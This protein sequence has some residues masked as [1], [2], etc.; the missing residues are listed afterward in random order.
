MKN[1]FLN[2]RIKNIIENAAADNCNAMKLMDAMKVT[3]IFKMNLLRI[4]KLKTSTKSGLTGFNMLTSIALTLIFFVLGISPVTA[5]VVRLSNVSLDEFPVLSASVFAADSSEINLSKL[6]KSDFTMVNNGFQSSLTSFECATAV[7]SDPATILLVLDCGQSMSATK[8]DF[9]KKI[10]TAFARNLAYRRYECGLLSFNYDYSVESG[11]TADRLLLEKRINA[12]KTTDGTN[13]TTMFDPTGKSLISLMVRAKYAKHVV[14]ISDGS[15]PHNFN[16][17]AYSLKANLQNVKF[18]FIELGSLLNEKMRKLAINT[19]GHF[20]DNIDCSDIS[21]VNIAI[22][23]ALELEKYIFNEPLCKIKWLSKPNC[24]FIENIRLTCNP[25][26]ASF[27]TSVLVPDSIHPQISYNV[28][29]GHLR[30]G[31]VPSNTK[32]QKKI[33]LTAKNGDV[34]VDSYLM[35]NAQFSVVDWGGSAPPFTIL[36]GE[37]RTITVEFSPKDTL[38]ISSELLL[39]SSNACFGNTI[40]CSG[41]IPYLKPT[42]KTLKIIFPN[43]GEKLLANKDTAIWWSG[44]VP[45]APVFLDYSSDGGGS[46][47]A[48]TTKAVGNSY[49][50]RVPSID[51]SQCVL[52]A[53]LMSASDQNDTSLV[54]APHNDAVT[55]LAWNPNGMQIVTVSADSTIRI[56]DAPSASLYAVLDRTVAAATSVAWSA[57]GKFIAAGTSIGTVNSWNAATGLPA[58]SFNGLSGRVMSVAFS[59]DS[60]LLAGSDANGNILIWHAETGILASTILKQSK[61]VNSIA[62]S[63]DGTMLATGSDDLAIKLWKTSDGSYIRTMNHTGKVSSIAFAPDS[64]RI[65]AGSSANDAIVF[66]TDDGSLIK[67]IPGLW[68]SAVAWSPDGLKIATGQM[69]DSIYI[70]NGND[71]SLENRLPKA[72]SEYI[73]TVAW[74]PFGPELASASGDSTARYWILNS[75]PYEVQEDVS[76]APWSI[77]K[78]TI[79]GKNGRHRHCLCRNSSR[80]NCKLLI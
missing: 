17:A 59:P 21:K 78:P 46:W 74:R 54:L 30:F 27:E 45:S 63:P 61:S 50:W 11:F 20:Y 76:D 77:V 24:A 65:V 73:T 14:I 75:I 25:L 48:I 18:H 36:A 37:K 58:N 71:Y 39:K 3:N 9:M 4:K 35:S 32:S 2:S 10:A 40:Y 5:Q 69:N 6:S 44:A 19:S 55:S 31:L 68:I 7:Q 8:L 56:W 64:K 57:D 1:N 52:R 72:H 70:Y 38:S 51:L 13:M 28:S 66:N 67:T 53:K 47:N 16:E 12:L 29:N 33:E 80:Y 49:T 22:G 41:G 60:K 42:E 15:T 23:A 34:T 26:K 62:F 43:G 79:T